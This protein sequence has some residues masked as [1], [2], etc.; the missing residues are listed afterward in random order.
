MTYIDHQREILLICFNRQTNDEIRIHFDKNG[1]IQSIDQSPKLYFK[2][3]HQQTC[4]YRSD[5]LYE[6]QSHSI[7][8]SQ[9][10]SS[11]FKHQTLL[12]PTHPL[13][14]P[15][16]DHIIP[17]VCLSMITNRFRHENLEVHITRKYSPIHYKND[18]FYKYRC[19]LGYFE[20]IEQQH[21]VEF[22]MHMNRNEKFSRE[23][24][25][26]MMSIANELSQMFE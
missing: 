7:L 6:F 4:S 24:L 11:I 2:C 3:F 17:I 1:R 10:Y 14:L 12:D 16:H 5:I 21:T 25:R 15:L 13:T 26:Y 19:V 20:Q 18:D 8:H 23:Y 22:Q 9:T